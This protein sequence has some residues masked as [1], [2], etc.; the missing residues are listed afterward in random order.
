MQMYTAGLRPQTNLNYSVAALPPDVR[1]WLCPAVNNCLRFGAMP[2]LR[3]GAT[4]NDRV[5]GRAEPLSHIGR[6]DRRKFLDLDVDLSVLVRRS[7]EKQVFNLE[8]TEKR[9]ALR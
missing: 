8:L 6:Q 1:R 7:D 9:R 5:G 4:I 3:G 2:R